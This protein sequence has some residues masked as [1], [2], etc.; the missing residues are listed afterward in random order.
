[1]KTIIAATDYSEN[2]MN[3]VKY[4]SGLAKQFNA[5]LVLFN[6][7][8][9]P[10]HAANTLLSA[11]SI[12]ALIDKNKRALITI[13]LEISSNYAI[14]VICESEAYDVEDELDRLMSKY[15]ADILV[16]GM[17]GNS[18]EQKLF[19]NTTTSVIKRAKYP[20]LA[21]PGAVGF[22]KI[23]KVL[24]ACDTAY[25][26]KDST[27]TQLRSVLERINAKVEVFSV[28]QEAFEKKILR[29][30]STDNLKVLLDGNRYK[31]KIVKGLGIISSIRAEVKA[32]HADLLVMVP[33][34]HSFW[35]S[36][37][38]VSKTTAMASQ[39]DVPL[40]SIPNNRVN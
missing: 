6:S 12:Q 4:A 18:I 24:F 13:A 39:S 1:M 14:E 36:I 37:I 21:I 11:N 5:K 2:A 27:L 26:Y 29:D 3:A 31:F 25:R 35:D 23:N 9:L 15:D 28:R 17:R 30:T 33:H 34:E 22:K 8:V 38:H 10:V 40:L 32:Y 19:G 7:F 20:V 16:L